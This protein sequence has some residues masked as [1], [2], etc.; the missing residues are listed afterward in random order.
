[1][2][3][4]KSLQEMDKELLELALNVQPKNCIYYNGKNIEKESP[5]TQTN[6]LMEY[7]V[8]SNASI[9]LLIDQPEDNIDN[10]AI[11]NDLTKWIS[12]LKYKRQ[13]IMVTHDANIVI[14]ADS[15]NL[16]ISDQVRSSEFKYVYGALEY[17]TNIIEA[18]LILDGGTDAVKR[19]LMKY[20]K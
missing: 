18:S 1:M 7:I 3:D 12:E 20:G 2:N 16:I 6:I 11:Y 17:E 4:S 9:P 10:K 5:G 14:N 8:N 19:R 13:I 15:E